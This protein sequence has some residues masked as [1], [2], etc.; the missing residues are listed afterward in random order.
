MNLFRSKNTN[1]KR[2]Y[3]ECYTKNLKRSNL[4]T[5]RTYLQKIR[6]QKGWIKQALNSTDP[7]GLAIY[8]MYRDNCNLHVSQKNC[9]NLSN[10]CSTRFYLFTISDRWR[11]ARC[12]VAHLIS[13]HGT[14]P[15]V[16]STVTRYTRYIYK[17]SVMPRN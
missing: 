17:P 16:W 11:T 7:F 14:W 4:S 9:N 5:K 13:L 10:R 15:L 3:I 8:Y 12:S 1:Y 6:T 2:C